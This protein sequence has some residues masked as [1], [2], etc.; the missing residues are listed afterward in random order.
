MDGLLSPGGNSPLSL[1]LSKCAFM[2]LSMPLGSCGKGLEG[3]VQTLLFNQKHL[4]H[5]AMRFRDEES[6]MS[7]TLMRSPF[8]FNKGD[9]HFS[10]YR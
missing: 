3:R 4:G 8:G 10:L 7:F 6:L 1:N 9:F 2:T 5:S